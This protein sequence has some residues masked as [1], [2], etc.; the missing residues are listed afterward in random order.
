EL[1]LHS[2]LTYLRDRL[3]LARE[4]LT[5]SGSVFVQISDENLHHVTEVMDEIFGR[6]NAVAVIPFVKTSGQTDKYLASV[7]DYL[8]WYA[9]DG[10]HLKYRQLYTTR[11][12]ATLESAYTWIEFEDGSFRKLTADELSGESAV[13]PGRRFMSASLFS[14]GFR[15]NTSVPYTFQ[16]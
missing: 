1:G 10:E 7:C 2:Y 15:T 4:L 9:R 14:Q 12:S 8:L 6:E 5:Q 16:N 11:S 13:P 3:L